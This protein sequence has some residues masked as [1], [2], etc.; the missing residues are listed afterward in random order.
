MHSMIFTKYLDLDK[1]NGFNVHIFFH[2]QS[3][4]VIQSKAELMHE[5]QIY[6]SKKKRQK[7]KIKPKYRHVHCFN[8]TLAACLMSKGLW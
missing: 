1:H 4:V 6:T 2:I 5:I 8:S 3:N 7:H